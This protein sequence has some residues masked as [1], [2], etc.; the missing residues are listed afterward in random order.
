MQNGKNV[1]T[2]IEIYAGHKNSTPIIDDG[3]GKGNSS[4]RNEKGELIEFNTAIAAVNWFVSNG[5][6]LE[7]LHMSISNDRTGKM[8]VVSKE[9]PAE[10]AKSEQQYYIKE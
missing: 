8:Y 9:I 5:W 3:K 4:Y 6:K 2:Y 1:K 7:S 10:V